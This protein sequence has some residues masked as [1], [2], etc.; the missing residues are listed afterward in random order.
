MLTL[1][2]VTLG[3][4][5]G[6]ALFPP[7]SIEL[8]VVGLALKHP[9]IPWLLL[10]A[11]IAI[12]QFI[13]KLVYFYAGRGSI[14]L[15]DFL[16][17]KAAAATEDTTHAPPP[18]G[19]RRYWHRLVTW[20]RSLW[21]WLRDKCHRHPYWMFGATAT[22]SIVGIPPFA[23]TTV[24]AGLAGLSLRSFALACIPGR[25]IRFSLLAASPIFIK[26]W[27]WHWLHVLHLHLHFL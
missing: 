7:L 11:V 8:F 20:I 21:W 2:L 12:G 26:H 10:G 24:L 27:H 19:L 3:V 1:L 6:S 4:A 15:P 17:R 25:F 23:A 14:R 18:T 22:S 13:G 9:D 16:H 5:I